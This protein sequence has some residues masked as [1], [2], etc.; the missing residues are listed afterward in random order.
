[1]T[2]FFVCFG[3]QINGVDARTREQVLRLFSESSCS[4]VVLLARHNHQS[5]HRD[6]GTGPH[7]VHVCQRFSRSAWP[8]LEGGTGEIPLSRLFGL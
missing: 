2:I 1:M 7:T 3:G 6:L 8:W 5:D 4:V